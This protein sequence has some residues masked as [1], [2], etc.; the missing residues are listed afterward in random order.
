MSYARFGGGSDV[1]VFAS[2]YGH[3]ECCGCILGEPWEHHSA[4]AVV[5]HMREHVAAGH[6]VPAYLLDPATYPPEDFEPYVEPGV[7][8]L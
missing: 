8:G 7:M 6:K 2:V 4:D 1:Y 5:A 3:V